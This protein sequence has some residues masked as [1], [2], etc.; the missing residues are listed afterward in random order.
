MPNLSFAEAARLAGVDAATISRKVRRG[1]ISVTRLPNGRRVIDLAELLRVY[2][3]AS[4]GPDMQASA[5]GQATDATVELL[6]RELES[7]REEK[8]RLL[9]MLEAEQ[10]ARRDLEQRL[11]PG[12]RRGLVDWLVGLFRR[13]GR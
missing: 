5:S 3:D 13:S 12:P 1:E 4:A 6:R 2:P 11:L 9:D 10:R 7:A 8:R